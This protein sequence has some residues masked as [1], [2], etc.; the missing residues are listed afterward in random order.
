MAKKGQKFKKVPLEKRLEAVREKLDVGK[1][2]SYL[3]KKYG[4]SWHTVNS[5]I[6]IYRRDRGLDI[7][8]KGRP[9]TDKNVSYKERYE[10][11]KKYRDYLK[12]VDQ[13]KK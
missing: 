1:S 9:K 3:G 5:W 4:V 12:E 8:E 7:L 10:I 11:L 6:R 13:E 2:Y